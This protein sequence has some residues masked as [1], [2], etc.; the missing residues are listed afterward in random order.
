MIKLTKKIIWKYILLIIV[1]FIILLF[2]NMK[3]NAWA[4]S[5]LTNQYP[6]INSLLQSNTL[7]NSDFTTLKA[8]NSTNA[9]LNLLTKLSDTIIWP[10]NND[11]ALA[12]DPN[13]DGGYIAY[14][15][16]P[17]QYIHAIYGY[18]TTG[19]P[20]PQNYDDLSTTGSISKSN[21]TKIV[22]MKN[23]D[24]VN[25]QDPS[26]NPDIT[27]NTSGRTTVVPTWSK[28]LRDVVNSISGKGDSYNGTTLNV[29]L[30]LQRPSN[31]N[32]LTIDANGNYIN[33]GN[34][35]I[36]TLNRSN[37]QTTIC[38]E[39]ATIFNSSYYGYIRGAGNTT[40]IYKDV[41]YYGAQFL[42]SSGNVNIETYGTINAFSLRYYYAPNDTKLYDCQG[43]GNQQNMQ[44]QNV[45]FGKDCV[46]NG[47][48]YSGNLLELTGNATVHDGA[49]VT[50]CPHTTASMPGSSS[51]STPEH[52]YGNN[53]AG[54]LYLKGG[55]PNVNPV[56]KIEKNA[57]LN[58][59]TNLASFKDEVNNNDP[60]FPNVITGAAEDEPM[61]SGYSTSGTALILDNGGK[62]KYANQSHSEINLTSDGP[63]SNYG[64]AYIGGGVVD[65][66][67]GSLKAT[68][69]NLNNKSANL[70][71]LGGEGKVFV[72]KNGTFNVG[73]PG[74]TGK[75]NMVYSSGDFKI[76][77]YKPKSLKIDRPNEQSNIIYG[78]GNVEM[79]GVKQVT[80]K[81]TVPFQYLNIPFSGQYI[82]TN[83]GGSILQA[84]TG[85][86]YSKILKT[87][88][89]NQATNAD[90]TQFNQFAGVDFTAIDDG[91]QLTKNLSIIDPQQRKITGTVTD[92][93]NG[94]PM[95]GARL[96]VTLQ[97]ADSSNVI[98]LG[99][100]GDNIAKLDTKLDS[101]Y[102]KDLNTDLEKTDLAA[103]LPDKDTWFIDHHDS[104]GEVLDTL[105]GPG[106]E[107]SPPWRYVTNSQV[108]SWDTNEFTI[109]IDQL[110]KN[111][112]A[113]HDQKIGTLLPSD[114]IQVTAVN[115][116]Q[117]SATKNVSISSLY[118]QLDNAKARKYYLLG[119]DIEIPLVYQDSLPQSTQPADDMLNVKGYI[120]PNMDTS[121]DPGLPDV[122][123][124]LPMTND[125]RPH[126]AVWKIAAQPTNKV[127]AEAKDYTVK[128][129]GTD[130]SGSRSPTNA[131]DEQGKPL[132]K[133]LLS[134]SYK[135]LNVPGYSGYK[136]LWQK[137]KMHLSNEP[138]FT[139]PNNLGMGKYQEK[140]FFKP[141]EESSSIS[142][143][144]FTRGDTINGD[145][146]SPGIKVDPRVRVIATDKNN[147][148][149][150]KSFSFQNNTLTLLPSDFPDLTTEGHFVPGIRFEIDAGVQVLN[151]AKELNLSSMH[152]S[153]KYE[154]TDGTSE[155]I[156]LGESGAIKIGNVYNLQLNV[157]SKIDFGQHSI[158]KFVDKNYTIVNKEDVQDN[159]HLTYTPIANNNIAVTVKLRGDLTDAS[160]NKWENALFYKSPST[161]EEQFLTS[162]TTIFSD[163]LPSVITS[164][165]DVQRKLATSWWND[166]D[167]QV[168]GIFLRTNKNIPH[169][170]TFNTTADWTVTN[171]I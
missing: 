46:Y 9:G 138:G 123:A 140:N 129:Y 83:Y 47:Y 106:S 148:S 2:F 65:I 115:N 86:D 90:H 70:I 17:N 30:A 119:D 72:N 103:V 153:T 10:S 130:K 146:D 97:R 163:T 159:L 110:V 108:I 155:N 160:S 57:S 52:S 93:E 141:K 96:H 99:D 165:E 101:V 59:K 28:V 82:V 21:I 117:A 68:A 60:R 25:S 73:A 26:S 69:N 27:I 61:K 67:E 16:T 41:N 53:T 152:M 7:R 44:A 55:G 132:P 6:S 85:K 95:S 49:R 42:Y 3:Q 122:S 38:L 79:R 4:A 109:D 81:G 128:F 63:L 51:G 154:H 102:L 100:T 166:N 56:L 12:A 168:A 76:N 50:L 150:A 40:E 116:Y 133:Y 54:G 147:N 91:P 112:D 169:W 74:A 121:L 80:D 149:Q 13:V 35:N 139:N 5:N 1:S 98:D 118:L 22:L 161:G 158:G 92:I 78:D 137:D 31:N 36:S 120:N 88:L 33:V 135:V 34:M 113:E 23:I 64:L 127:T 66:G 75:I 29:N 87:L 125:N 58:V 131:F 171:S 114:K 104:A 32:T 24:L 167:Q 105:T 37:F 170:G 126:N 84:Q 48:T 157:P 43:N 124:N 156:A 77:V 11:Y 144:T 45:D 89:G 142:N 143:V 111:Y 145:Y 20:N 15:Q 164:N 39:N 107:L 162:E 71:Q 18:S 19:D 134:Y 151:P 62:V 136:Q 8:S 94:E 14:V